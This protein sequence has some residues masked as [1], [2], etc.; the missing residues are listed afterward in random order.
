MIDIEKETMVAKKYRGVTDHFKIPD[1]DLI[2]L[3][4]RFCSSVTVKDIVEWI[5]NGRT[6][7]V[8]IGV[9]GVM[10]CLR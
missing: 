10:L 3:A 5:E 2:T 7:N 4:N 9:K 6:G 8:P 1:E